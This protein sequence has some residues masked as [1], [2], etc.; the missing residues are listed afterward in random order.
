MYFLRWIFLSILDSSLKFLFQENTKTK[1]G[2]VRHVSFPQ[3]THATPHMRK[4]LEIAQIYLL[5]IWSHV[6]HSLTNSMCLTCFS[7][8]FFYLCSFI[9]FSP[10]L[11]APHF[12]PHK[13]T[14]A[15]SHTHGHHK[16]PHTCHFLQSFVMAFINNWWREFFDCSKRVRRVWR[17]PFSLSPKI[18]AGRSPAKQSPTATE[19]APTLH[20]NITQHLCTSDITWSSR[21]CQ[22]TYIQAPDSRPR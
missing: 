7:P 3:R 13:Q 5:F 19:E 1:D 10:H 2:K 4:Y 20:N 12:L 11:Y 14:Q 21:T 16:S 8:L 18:H 15:L 22:V 6:P 9:F 17:Q